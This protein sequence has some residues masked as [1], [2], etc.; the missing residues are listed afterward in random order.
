MMQL[1]SFGFSTNTFK[2]YKCSENTG[3][4]NDSIGIRLVLE[5][6]VSVHP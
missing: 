4:K 3:I 6:I 2:N 1:F 5:N